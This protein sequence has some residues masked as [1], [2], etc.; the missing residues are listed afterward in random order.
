MYRTIRRTQ[1]R[2]NDFHILLATGASRN[3]DGSYTKEAEKLLDDVSAYSRL[4]HVLYWASCANRFSVLRTPQG[5][6]RLASRGLMTSQQLRVLESLDLPDNQRHNACLE[7][8]MIRVWKGIDDGTLRSENSFSER[9]MDQMCQLRANC[10]SI[11]DML[12]ARMPLPY[13]HLV[14]TLVDSFVALSP[15]ALYPDLGVY[16]IISVGVL[17]LFYTGFCWIIKFCIA[18]LYSVLTFDSHVVTV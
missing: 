4:M 9:L 6:E 14:Q 18:S 11:G 3:R 10:G 13:T 2:F 5:L 1:G 15:F 12:A 8:M 16:L 17:T 7:W